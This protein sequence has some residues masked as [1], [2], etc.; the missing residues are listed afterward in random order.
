VKYH[1][2]WKNKA[3]R[4]RSPRLQF[5]FN[6]EKQHKLEDSHDH[7]TIFKSVKISATYRKIFRVVLQNQKTTQFM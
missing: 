4:S 7:V 1:R 5:N 3:K 2:Y 6:H